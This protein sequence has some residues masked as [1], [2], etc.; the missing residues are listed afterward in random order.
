MTA[1]LSGE[2][3]DSWQSREKSKACTDVQHNMSVNELIWFLREEQGRGILVKKKK[4][5]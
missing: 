5:K 3:L 4:K 2:Q 1:Q